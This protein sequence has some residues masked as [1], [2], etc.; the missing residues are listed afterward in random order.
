MNGRVYDPDLGRFLSPDPNVQFV[1]DL[2]SY[3]RYT[4]A[5]NNPL[6]Y[7][8]PTGYFIDPGFDI[9]VGVVL[10]VASVAVCAASEGAAC[11]LAFAVVGA[12]YGT[13]SAI[14]SG[15]GFEQSMAVGFT[16]FFLGQLGGAATGAIGG[17]LATQIVGGAISGAAS[18]AIMTETF[19]GGKGLGT[20][21]LTGALTGAAGAAFGYALRQSLLT[22]A[23]VAAQ[24]G[25]RDRADYPFSSDRPAASS[26][27][28]VEN[29]DGGSDGSV[30]IV[31]YRNYRYNSG[32]DD[33]AEI[34]L[35]YK[36]ASGSCRDPNWVQ[37]VETNSLVNGRTAS[38]FI[39][40]V[41]VSDEPYYYPAK[42]AAT[43]A[44]RGGYD[45]QFYDNPYRA[46]ALGTQPNVQ[47]SAHVSLV[48]GAQS[49]PLIT[50]S[51]GFS[52]NAT[53]GLTLQPLSV[54]SPSPFHVG[55]LP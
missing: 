16:G 45:T 42:L 18:S 3:N 14:N 25:G 24:Q 37:T 46:T 43:V 44:G 19:G 53:G 5:A 33:G 7:T 50:F 13:A 11:P 10:T 52:T 54:V 6:R 48:C 12:I 15:A 47:W 1:A 4:Y 29:A 35:G 49:D 30:D 31:K 41:S 20:N 26:R 36:S 22:Q 2:Q 27:I 8:D 28:A 21:I 55:A 40:S 32:S 23:D 9:F 38:P 34:L 39:D 51:W 17:G